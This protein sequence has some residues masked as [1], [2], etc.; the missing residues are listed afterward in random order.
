[1]Q[2]L[3]QQVRR[4]VGVL[5]EL[6]VVSQQRQHGVTQV[7]VESQRHVAVT[8]RVLHNDDTPATTPPATKP[9]TYIDSGSVQ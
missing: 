1:V 8:H 7:P 4:V 3:I 6:R 9:T 2:R 5:E